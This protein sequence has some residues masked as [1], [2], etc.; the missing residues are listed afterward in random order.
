MDISVIT[1][2]FKGSRFIP[3]LI[4]M[5]EKNAENA[6]NLSV[7]WIVVNDY[8]DEEFIIDERNI[9]HFRLIVVTNSK[10]LGIQASRIN[11]IRHASGQYIMM[12]DQD[13]EIQPETLRKMYSVVKGHDAVLCNGYAEEADGDRKPLFSN[14]NINHAND[15]NYYFYFGNVIASPGLVLIKK[16]AIPNE[17]LDNIM[18][19]NGADDWLLWVL[20]L[21]KGNQFKILNELFYVHKN[22]GTNTSDDLEKMLCSSEEALEILSSLGVVKNKLIYVYRR[23]L[24]M[25]FKYSNR[26]LIEK[27]AQYLANM[28]IMLYVLKHKQ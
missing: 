25:R 14:K 24:H 15:L 10:N 9:K 3:H 7:E 16:E 20:Y 22:D 1:P 26:G 17:W 11:G 12:L 13:D 27:I 28:D 18:K 8:P 21:A 19:T 23:R 6:A 5:L 4:E 2:I